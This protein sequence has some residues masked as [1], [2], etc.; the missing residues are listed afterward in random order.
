MDTG[1]WLTRGM[2]WLALTLYV[3]S[4]WA[5]AVTAG[6]AGIRTARGLNGFG[7]IAFIGHV[8]S[9]FISIIIGV[10]PLLTPILPGKRRS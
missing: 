6:S 2:V 3:A 4:E 10:M 7:L 5:A 8:L 9:A 1:E